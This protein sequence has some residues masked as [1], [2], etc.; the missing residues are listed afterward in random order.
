MH[1]TL[2]AP[3]TVKAV[4][5]EDGTATGIVEAIVSVLSRRAVNE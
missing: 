3:A 5:A 4:K 2:I 1:K